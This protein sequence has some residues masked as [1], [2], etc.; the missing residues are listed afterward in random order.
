MLRSLVN[1][2]PHTPQ[3]QLM[4]NP[5]AS[6]LNT[7]GKAASWAVAIAIV[8]GYSYFQSKPKPFNTDDQHEWNAAILAKQQKSAA[9]KPPTKSNP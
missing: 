4:K 1:Y 8:G 3:K 5:I 6:G 9:A 2:E 7:P